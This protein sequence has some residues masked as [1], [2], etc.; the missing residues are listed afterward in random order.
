MAV[1]K[2]KKPRHVLE[3]QTESLNEFVDDMPQ[4]KEKMVKQHKIKPGPSREHEMFV[5]QEIGLDTEPLVVFTA[6]SFQQ[7]ENAIETSVEEYG[8]GMEESRQYDL[9]GQLNVVTRKLARNCF[10]VT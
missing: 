2:R 3:E 7:Q 6:D 10:P 9:W 4:R 8:T 1:L 5:K